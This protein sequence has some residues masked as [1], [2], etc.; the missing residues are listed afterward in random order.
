M[1][2]VIPTRHEIMARQRAQGECIAA[3]FPQFYPRE[4]LRAHGFH[5]MELWAPAVSG[6]ENLTD[7]FQPY[8]C[9][10][11]RAGTQFLRQASAIPVDLVLVPHTCDSLQGVGSVLRDFI[12]PPC[13]VLTL[14]HPR[15]GHPFDKAF[16]VN[17]LRQLSR[18]LG[19]I[20]GK[21]PDDTALMHAITAEEHADARLLSLYQ[22][23]HSVALTDKEFYQVVRSREY[24]P[25]D[26]FVALC[27]GLPAG[28]AT[29]P[30]GIRLCLSGILAEPMS[31]FDEINALGASVVCDDLACG[32]RRIYASG[33]SSDPFERMA[34]RLLSTVPEPTRGQ[35][36]N[37][38]LKHLHHLVHSHQ[39]QGLIFY[40]LKFCEPELFDIPHIRRFFQARGLP[41]L[42]L[43]VDIGT[44]LSQQTRTRLQ[45]FV[46]MLK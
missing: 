45:A 21:R 20:A 7:H 13:P 41:V 1:T 25:N 30:R 17:E 40:D 12:R 35:D 4:L 3:V 19:N 31:L 8:T 42:H 6:N 15:G 32:A 9:A 14:Y 37:D 33:S 44:A 24:L 11:A 39:V 38:R 10:I 36:M 16:L 2:I 46:E 27:D 28:N 29:E 22:R 26:V 23:R 34:E 43:D 18:Q 5:P